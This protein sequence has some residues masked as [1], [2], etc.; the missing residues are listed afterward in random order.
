MKKKIKIILLLF[1]V[2]IFFFNQDIYTQ[3]K[4]TGYFCT[5]LNKLT[6][7]K[8]TREYT[9][10]AD[11]FIT[12]YKIYDPTYGYYL[13]ITATHYKPEKKIVVSLDDVTVSI[14]G[15]INTEEIEYETPSMKIFGRR[16]SFQSMF[17][18]QGRLPNDLALKFVSKKFEN[19]KVAHITR[20]VDYSDGSTSWYILDEKR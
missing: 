7:I 19:V 1:I 15:H 10:V 6:S 20:G 13:N 2:T 9:Q 17:D 5:G 18:A 3:T 11:T 16:G 12:T 14:G 8:Y 4:Y